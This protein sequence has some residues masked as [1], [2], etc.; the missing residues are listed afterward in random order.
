M[1]PS[2]D[3]RVPALHRTFL[4][5]SV[6]TLSQDRRLVGTAIC[7][8]YLTREMDEYSDLDLVVVVAPE[9]YDEVMSQRRAVAESL[10]TLLSAF[11]AEHVG[12][13][14]MLIGLYDDPLLHVDLKFVRPEAFPTNSVEVPEVLWE[15]EGVLTKAI[16]ANLVSELVLDPQWVEDRYWTW[17]HATACAVGRGELFTALEAFTYLRGRVLGPMAKLSAGL[18]P[19][20]IRHLERDLPQFVPAF[21][22]TMPCRH[23]AG[24]LMRALFACVRLY[25]RLRND[26][27]SGQVVP[28]GDA[29]AAVLQFLR[30]VAD[31]TSATGAGDTAPS[32]EP[33]TMKR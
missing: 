3:P 11:T 24:E 10:G 17:I 1:A 21:R 16:E 18:R 4:K 14:E 28:N 13:P 15:R 19:F 25:Q 23:E 6:R 9:C 26:I 33:G 22:E 20:E 30:V 29:E 32:P 27:G 2:V 12:R 31:R 5:R 7:G 8:S